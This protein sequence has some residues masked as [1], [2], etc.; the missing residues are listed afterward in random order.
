MYVYITCIHNNIQMCIYHTIVVQCAHH[1]HRTVDACAYLQY[2]YIY[3]YI[4]QYY[5][6]PNVCSFWTACAKQ[7]VLK[8][9]PTPGKGVSPQRTDTAT[10]FPVSIIYYFTNCFGLDMKM[11]S[12][13]M[14]LNNN[15]ISEHRFPQSFAP[16]FKNH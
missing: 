8:I 10:N 5:A 7:L 16:A 13:G 9:K 11:R 15:V 2:I 3:I 12:I 1:L 4:I 6:Y 14:C